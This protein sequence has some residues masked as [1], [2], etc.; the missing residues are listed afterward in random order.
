LLLPLS[1]FSEE[2]LL[3]AI[4]NDNAG[5]AASLVT[6]VKFIYKRVY[7]FYKIDDINPFC[8]YC[9]TPGCYLA[10]KKLQRSLLFFLSCE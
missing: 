6:E 2:Q 8:L 1:P 3:K 9:L 4:A 10:Q 5:M 7:G